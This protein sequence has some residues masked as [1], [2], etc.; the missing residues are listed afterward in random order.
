MPGLHFPSHIPTS[1]VSHTS[2]GADDAIKK[3][4]DAEKAAGGAEKAAGGDI[5]EHTIPRKPVVGNGE[6]DTIPSPSDS[7]EPA[8]GAGAASP[9]SEKPEVDV[10][11]QGGSGG[12][13]AKKA[14]GGND[15]TQSS[16]TQADE[17]EGFSEPS[18]HL[19]SPSKHGTAPAPHDDEGFVDGDE[20]GDEP[21][22]PAAKN[23]N[24]KTEPED[25][26]DPKVK[27]HAKIDEDEP[28]SEFPSK[29]HGSAEETSGGAVGDVPPKSGWSRFNPFGSKNPGTQTETTLDGEARKTG[30]SN[31]NPFSRNKNSGA[32]NPVEESGG[33]MG[34]AGGVVGGVGALGAAGAMSGVDLTAVTE[35]GGAALDAIKG[36]K[37]AGNLADDVVDAEGA[38]KK[39][40]GEGANTADGLSDDLGDST[41]G[42]GKPAAP[43]SDLASKMRNFASDNKSTL[44]AGAGGLG[45]GA[46]AAAAL[47]DI[48]EPSEEQVATAQDDDSGMGAYGNRGNQI[49]S[50]GNP[51]DVMG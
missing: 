35:G 10:L 33:G 30:L 8:K 23:H 17:D 6:P 14:T 50:T 7:A 18:N 41:S 39:T 16:H 47:K 43:G 11:P 20:D 9:H 34:T 24:S 15:A 42:D 25:G 21:V 29:S 26:S 3:A 28:G 32:A 13:P 27:P 19:P 22:K 37:T 49:P 5:I 4:K 12:E 46:L 40:K 2:E 45:V 31:Y 44:L 1:T 51:M 48:Q 38:A 36:E